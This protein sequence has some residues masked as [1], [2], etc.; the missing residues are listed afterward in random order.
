MKHLFKKGLSLLLAVLMVTSMLPMSAFAVAF[1]GGEDSIGRREEAVI[2]KSDP[3]VD[4]FAGMTSRGDDDARRPQDRPE[5]PDIGDEDDK[6]VDPSWTNEAVTATINNDGSWEVKVSTTA[7]TGTTGNWV[8]ALIPDAKVNGGGMTP[9]EMWGAGS[10]TENQDS[11]NGMSTRLTNGTGQVRDTHYIVVSG[12]DI[13]VSGGVFTISSS[14]SE[15]T[16]TRRRVLPDSADIAEALGVETPISI[17]VFFYCQGSDTKVVAGTSNYGEVEVAAGIP[18]TTYLL[19]KSTNELTF[20]SGTLGGKAWPTGGT[21]PTGHTWNSGNDTVSIPI[22]NTLGDAVGVDVDQARSGVSLPGAGDSF[23]GIGANTSGSTTIAQNGNRLANFIV[24]SASGTITLPIYAYELDESGSIDKNAPMA[25][26]TITIQIVSGAGITMAPINFDV[27]YGFTTA[28]DS[29]PLRVINVNRTTG[30]TTTA[31]AWSTVYLTN[32]PNYTTGWAV[33]AVNGVSGSTLLTAKAGVEG[34]YIV[35]QTNKRPIIATNPSTPPTVGSANTNVTA[36]GTSMLTLNPSTAAWTIQNNATTTYDLV[37]TMPSTTARQKTGTTTV[38]MSGTTALP[39]PTIPVTV[40]VHGGYAVFHHKDGSTTTVAGRPGYQVAAANTV[41]SVGIPSGS[42]ANS[43]TATVALPVGLI[44]LGARDAT[45]HYYELDDTPTYD[46]VYHLGS[47]ESWA[48]GGSS[49]KN[50]ETGVTTHTVVTEKAVKA[51]NRFDGWATSNGGSVVYNGGE[52]V[53]LTGDLDLYPVWTP[54]Y[55][56]SYDMKGHGTAPGSHTNVPSGTKVTT[57]SVSNVTGYTFKGWD[58]NTAGTTVVYTAG[59][60]TAAITAN[61]TLY[62]VWEANEHKII[63]HVNGPSGGSIANTDSPVTFHYGDTGVTA[64]AGTIIGGTITGWNFVKWNTLANGS[65][66]DYAAGASLPTATTDADINLYAQ[67]TVDVTFDLNASSVSPAATGLSAV[68]ATQKVA[69]NTGHATDPGNPSS[70]NWAFSKWVI[71]DSTT[72]VNFSTQTFSGPTTIKATWGAKDTEAIFDLNYTG[73]ASPTTVSGTPS[74]NV[75]ANS[76]PST[77]RSGWRFDGWYTAATGGSVVA[78]PTFPAAGNSAVT[79]YAHWTELFTVSYDMKGHGTAPGSHTNVPSGTKVTTKSVSNVTGYTFKGWDTNTAGTTVVYTAGTETAAIT[80]NTTLYAVWEANEYEVKYEAGVAAGASIVSGKTPQK[81]TYGQPSINAHTAADAITGAGTGWTFKNWRSSETGNPTYAGGASLNTTNKTAGFTLT[82]QWQVAVTYDANYPEATPAGTAGVTIP[83][84]VNVDYNGSLTSAALGTP[85]NLTDYN[86]DGWYDAA[87][88][89]NKVTTAKQFTAPTTIY[90][91]WT[92]KT[93]SYIFNPNN[94]AFG[95]GVANDGSNYKVTGK[96]GTTITKPADPTRRDYTFQGWG[97][98]ATSTT[99]ITP[100]AT[101]PSG[102]EST[103]VYA[104]WTANT[105]G[106]VFDPNGG[107]FAAGETGLQGDGTVKKTGAASATVTAPTNPTRTKCAFDG[108]YTAATGGTKVITHT[109]TGNAADGTVTNTVYAHWIPLYDVTYNNGGHGTVDTSKNDLNKATRSYTVLGSSTVIPAGTGENW[110]GAYFTDTNGD[111]WM[112]TGWKSN[113]DGK[114]YQA[115]QSFQVTQDTVLTA[116]WEQYYRVTLDEPHSATTPA[117]VLSASIHASAAFTPAGAGA[118]NLRSDYGLTGG[119]AVWV[120]KGTAVTMASLALTSGASNY[121][122]KTWDQDTTGASAGSFGA[123]TSA[124][125]TFTPAADT[126]LTPYY[127]MKPTRT[128]AADYYHL[129]YATGATVPANRN[130]PKATNTL[131]TYTW[132]KNDATWVDIYIS[133]KGSTTA[134]KALPAGAVKETV[135]ASGNRVYEFQRD[136]LLT[137]E[138]G[139]YTIR[140]SSNTPDATTTNHDATDLTATLGI[141][142]TP[143]PLEEVNVWAG[144]GSSKTSTANVDVSGRDI[145]AYHDH[146]PTTITGGNKLTYIWYVSKGSVGSTIQQAYHANNWQNNTLNTQDAVT[147]ANTYGTAIAGA[148]DGP[149][150]NVDQDAY[151]GKYIYAVVT[152]SITGYGAVVTNPIAVD[153]DAVVKVNKDN[154]ST[155]TGGNYQVYLVPQT[156]SANP[157]SYATMPNS[158]VATT[159]TAGTNQYA[160]QPSALTGGV[161]YDIYVNKVEGDISLYVKT[162]KTV[163]TQTAAAAAP[164]VDFYS[165]TAQP[166]VVK[167]GKDANG[168]NVGETFANADKP[169]TQL[170]T[171][172]AGAATITVTSGYGVFKGSDVTAKTSK[173]FDQ[174]YHVDWGKANTEPT[175]GLTYPETGADAKQ[176]KANASTSITNI[177]KP[178]WVGAQLDQNLYTVVGNIWANNA[179]AGIVENSPRL[180]FGTYEFAGTSPNGTRT[181]SVTFTGVPRSGVSAGAITGK[182]SITASPKTNPLSTI[183]GYVTFQPTTANETT[184]NTALT[185]SRLDGANQNTL[186]TD[187]AGNNSQAFTIVVAASTYI[188]TIPEVSGVHAEATQDWSANTAA[189][190]T[191]AASTTANWT[192]DYAYTAPGTYT[193]KVVNRGNTTL[194]VTLNVAK[195]GSSVSADNGYVYGGK[196]NVTNVL[197]ASG[198]DMEDATNGVTFTGLATTFP[199]MAPNAEKTFTVTIPTS[200]AVSGTANYAFE[201]TSKETGKTNVFGPS[202]TYNLVQKINPLKI[203]DIQA[204]SAGTNTWAPSA[205]A[206][207]NST[208]IP[209]GVNQAAEVEYKWYVAPTTTNNVAINKTGT[210]TLTGTGLR[211]VTAAGVTGNNYSLQPADQGMTLYLVAHNRNTGNIT[212]ADFVRVGNLPYDLDIV[213]KQNDDEVTQTQKANYKVYLWSGADNAFTTATGGGAIEA[214]ATAA[215]D[216]VYTAT[217]LVPGT[218]YK[219]FTNAVGGETGA[220]WQ[221]SGVSVNLNNFGAANKPTVVYRNVILSNTLVDN[222]QYN[223]AITAD[224][225]NFLATYTGTAPYHTART[226]SLKAPTAKFG[227]TPVAS[228][229][230]AK[231]GIDQWVQSGTTVTLEYPAWTKDY[232][233][234]WTGATQTANN[235]ATGS[236]ATKKV[237]AE[238]TTI[239]TELELN[240]YDMPVYVVGDDG[241]MVVEIQL[242]NQGSGLSFTTKADDTANGLWNGTNGALSNVTANGAAAAFKVP[243]GTYEITAEKAAGTTI[244]GYRKPHNATPPTDYT[245]LD[246]DGLEV[247]VAATGG[248]AHADVI[249]TATGQIMTVTDNAKTVDST[250]ENAAGAAGYTDE[251]SNGTAAT[252][253]TLPYGYDAKQ[254]ILTVTNSS[255][256][257]DKINNVNMDDSG[258]TG[259]VNKITVTAPTAP[260]ILLNGSAGM[261]KNEST[262]A[263]VDIKAGLTTGTYVSTL[264]F[265]FNSEE[266]NAATVAT[267]T[268]TLTVVVKPAE[269]T[270]VSIT[271]A[272]GTAADIG[273]A[274]VEL[275]ESLLPYQYATTTPNLWNTNL[276][277]ETTDYAYRWYATAANVNLAGTW[278]GGNFTPSVAATALSPKAGTNELEGATIANYPGQKIWL[279]VYAT[280]AEGDGTNVIKSAIS[281]PVTTGFQPVVKV[282]VDDV[283]VTAEPAATD[284]IV[285]ITDDS[286]AAGPWNTKWSTAKGGFVPVDATGKEVSLNATGTY[287]ASVNKYKGALATAGLV[288]QTTKLTL[289]NDEITVDYYTVN[290]VDTKAFDGVTGLGEVFDGDDDRHGP[291]PVFNFGGTTIAD[292]TPVLKGQ[293]VNAAIPNPGWT[294]DY[295]LTWYSKLDNNGTGTATAPT[296]ANAYEGTTATMSAWAGGKQTSA[297]AVTTGYQ[298]IAVSET[299]YVGGRLEQNTYTIIGTVKGTPGNIIGVTVEKTD[300]PTKTYTWDT[301]TNSDPTL[302]TV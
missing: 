204:T 280:K 92:S 201:F 161:T 66:T 106:Y 71:G 195:S 164:V 40:T 58:T 110:S 108:W 18:S 185:S 73:S 48:N 213:V 223:A 128:P 22:Y 152:A 137:L 245:T 10:I 133:D 171:A 80:A 255:S 39:F 247:T 163:S 70:T 189:A 299:L 268:Y 131:P 23:S 263:T 206:I 259:D 90:A 139:T 260:A 150:V 67:W 81:F 153:Y 3:I 143:D 156:G 28:V 285:T 159:N 93:Y 109:I 216:G 47:G 208:T 29:D 149:M 147:A 168:A 25:N 78:T 124:N 121:I 123:A 7:T 85:G 233:F 118:S 230:G 290:A 155:I 94:G 174:D 220:N 76:I 248:D 160:T 205:L 192:V 254:L 240:L 105:Y 169:V 12:N 211:E 135:D 265:S 64:K 114:T 52:S 127:W 235:K 100:A 267:M 244:Q 72:A 104:V 266:N 86:F 19:N 84:P 226:D 146:K 227:T 113:A 187:I 69:V 219:V 107:A 68:P 89:G 283:D 203:T 144:G 191:T 130:F 51:N 88:G 136:Y 60:E 141:Y 217:G 27:D 98:T 166:T 181:Q 252:T 224:T 292:K 294:Q 207:A 258:F 4:T 291:K 74:S 250:L 16:T 83:A 179:T 142:V 293:S 62:A 117:N 6:P 140:F 278:S 32:A 145:V 157:A 221:N 234:T 239:D 177:D 165:V 14:S 246:K 229:T 276:I 178:T 50:D 193:F 253:I 35:A 33:P 194:D 103:T 44:V 279:V 302:I 269:F 15:I 101:M 1:T 296:Y 167:D 126:L 158:A 289:T 30:S 79:Y 261:E 119:N 75:P 295:K 57:K 298:N 282:A 24:T 43:D 287:T 151:K 97:E 138:D 270:D 96:V 238:D 274:T 256:G 180:T 82:A 122:F 241:G 37:V 212:E 242:T 236:T 277:T 77:T 59:T 214:I 125:T 210:G 95:S 232:T 45:R 26:A 173:S 273:T 162:G 301:A 53:T 225:P 46:V 170:T 54:L 5:I 184:I 175:S 154:S 42:W 115:N 198:S 49:V 281:D 186:K 182:Y 172:G 129:N 218:T 111:H 112:F 300:D 31:F 197:T 120:K 209:A 237:T 257:T 17:M 13:T 65:G 215:D 286:G 99:T 251:A 102:V 132:T 271:K 249:V 91:H 284:Y 272:S 56:V 8:L 134:N 36:L 190:P 222:Q 41:G 188:L 63:Y 264:V 55:T 21:T 2:D 183:R 228:A 11:E 176:D 61:T 262:T 87:S 38:T 148:G 34:Q 288:A 200:L 297:N 243:A 202:V 9:S 196:S 275:G 231:A 20:V 199:A 116:Q